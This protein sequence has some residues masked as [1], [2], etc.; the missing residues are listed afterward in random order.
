[1]RV[2]IRLS[3]VYGVGKITNPATLL[4]R[5]TAKGGQYEAYVGGGLVSFTAAEIGHALTGYKRGEEEYR[6]LPEGAF[7]VL[8][9]K[10]ATGDINDATRLIRV[11]HEDIGGKMTWQAS[12]ACYQICRIAVGEFVQVTTCPACMGR[13]TVKDEELLVPCEACDATG[14]R[15]WSTYTRA[16]E[17]GLPESTFR[18]QG[19]DAIYSGRFHRLAEWEE[20]GL[21]RVVG[22]TS[23]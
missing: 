14:Y 4:A 13:K 18:G 7:R 12:A 21:R 6:S 1:M 17:L 3:I 11:L 20:I 10:Y 22:K 5:A 19:P 23:S 9:L 8:L 16:S 15:R 2:A